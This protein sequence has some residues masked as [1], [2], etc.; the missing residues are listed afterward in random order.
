M[1]EESKKN[2]PFPNELVDAITK[3]YVELSF[4]SFCDLNIYNLVKK[5]KAITS[6]VARAQ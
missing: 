5:N 1:E 3:E 2:L 6:M 4:S